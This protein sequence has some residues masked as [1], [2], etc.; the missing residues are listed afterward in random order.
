MYNSYH[1]KLLKYTCF[2]AKM[3]ATQTIHCCW[4]HAC[5]TTI[6]FIK[7]SIKLGGSLWL[8]VILEAFNFSF[9]H[10]SQK[11]SRKNFKI[12]SRNTEFF[13]FIF[14]Q[15]GWWLDTREIWGCRTSGTQILGISISVYD[16]LAHV[17]LCWH[18]QE[19]TAAKRIFGGKYPWHI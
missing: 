17:F 7:P 9:S 10:P 4:L 5:K 19:D 13:H 18:L 1:V 14:L 2:S 3:N 12:H 6:L 11:T 8:P 15:C 16:W